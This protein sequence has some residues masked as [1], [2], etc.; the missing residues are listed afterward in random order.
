ML[1]WPEGNAW[2][3]RRLASP[4]GARLHS[5]QIVLR[6]EQGKH[7]VDV[8]AFNTAT[9]Q[10]ERWQAEQA[11]VALPLF[12]A[13]RVVQNAPDFLKQAAATTVYAPWL[14]ANIHIDKPLFDRPGPAP[15]WDNVIYGDAATA[16]G[17]GYVDAMHQSLLPVVNATVL[18]YYRALGDVEGGP[19][20]GRE[21]LLQTPW[22]Q[23]RDDILRE[24]GVA[25]PDLR[26]KTTRMD[27]TRYGHAMAIPV[28]SVQ[29]HVGQL[30]PAFGR[31]LF[32]HSDWATY[33]VFEE[34]FV[35]GHLAGAGR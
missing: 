21:A 18:S 9:Q 10:V 4:L 27:I 34:A 32:A 15:S 30:P 3:T 29:G 28:P 12:I 24:L 19:A 7:G 35:R 6:V 26:M 13:A 20:K 11:I 2:L 14:V 16:P 25:H 5:G 33:S 31:I 23:W 17:L 1:T 22:T 8:D